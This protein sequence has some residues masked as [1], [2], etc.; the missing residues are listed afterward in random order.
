MPY[1]NIPDSG[2]GGATAKIVGKIQGEVASLVLKK[3]N[4][5]VNKLNVDGCPSSSELSRI[6]KQKDLLFNQLSS[7][8]GKL[9]KFKALP[10]KLKAPLSGF[11]AALRIILSLPIPQ[12]VPPGFGLP[13]NITTKYA[14]VMHLLKEFI[15]QIDELIQSVEVV[16]ETP[17]LNLKSLN[18]LL[19]RAESAI[20]ACEIEKALL[21]QIS[22]GSVTIGDLDSLGLYKNGNLVLSTLGP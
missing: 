14:D 9:A 5:I 13:I 10:K 1:V 8:D 11:K 6:R 19:S 15:K 16:I 3:A 21:E 12:S 17:S 18:G 7:I 22:D 20:K 4:E 2:L